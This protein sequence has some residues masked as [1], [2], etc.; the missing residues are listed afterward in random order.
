MGFKPNNKILIIDG[1]GAQASL[2]L[3]K[4]ILGGAIERRARN[5]D[6][7]LKSNSRVVLGCTEL[8]VL[9]DR[10]NYNRLV[11]PLKLSVEKIFQDETKL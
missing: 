3:H 6:E 1:M 4:R 5:A 11:D 7:L 10:L 8:S 2:L 9:A